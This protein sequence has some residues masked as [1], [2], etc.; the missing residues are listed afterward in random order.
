M[1]CGVREKD[2]DLWKHLCYM[3]YQVS[4]GKAPKDSRPDI[5]HPYLTSQV[6]PTMLF[7]RG[8]QEGYQGVKP[9]KLLTAAAWAPLYLPQKEGQ[10]LR[11]VNASG[12][13]LHT[14]A[15]GVSVKCSVHQI[16]CHSLTP[17]DLSQLQSVAEAH[18]QSGG[19]ED[20]QELDTPVRIIDTGTSL[21]LYQSL[22]E[23]ATRARPHSSGSMQ[24]A[25][26]TQHSTGPQSHTTTPCVVR[27]A[28]AGH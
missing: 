17:A 19:E 6:V 22:G 10:A 7:P 16:E 27:R 28:H 11:M 18:R 8:S 5:S 26:P 21:A 2:N 25:V 3:D 23:G 24:P 1:R 14:P 13:S 9:V 4:G 15:W 12:L 20:D